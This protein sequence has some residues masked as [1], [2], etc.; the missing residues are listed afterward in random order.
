MKINWL[1]LSTAVIGCELVGLAG[2]PF[3]LSAIPSWYSTLDKP[4]FAPPHW[5]FAPVWT[6]LYL[7]MGISLYLI[8][9]KGT[10]KKL[11][12]KALQLFI[13]QLFLNLIWTPLFFGLRSPLLALIDIIVLWI[14]IVVT[15]RMFAPISKVA[16][17]LLVPYL[18]WVTFATF[19]N[20]GIWLLN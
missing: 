7:L 14:C 5:L 6:I 2:T 15:I 12:R 10:K 4:F 3:T 18:A 11:V 9:E 19:L 20:A 16:G 13:V 8:W 17:Y 1:K